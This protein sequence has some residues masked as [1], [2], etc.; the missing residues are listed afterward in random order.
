MSSEI[1]QRIVSRGLDGN[2]PLTTEEMVIY[3]LAVLES[4][5]MLGGISSLLQDASEKYLSNIID[6]L[7]S[8]GCDN[9][10]A[11][12]SD[13]RKI[14]VDTK[15]FQSNN[16]LYLLENNPD[17]LSI[18]VR[19]EDAIQNGDVGVVLDRYLRLYSRNS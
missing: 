6:S 19:A 8:S 16:R 4:D 13:I 2:P 12:L 17:L 15:Y 14:L 18:M 3:H 9:V 10:A 1:I 11:L 7:I 5:V